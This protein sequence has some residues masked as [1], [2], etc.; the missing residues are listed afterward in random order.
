M[1]KLTRRSPLNAKRKNIVCAS[2][3]SF[4][5]AIGTNGLKTH[6][7]ISLFKPHKPA[8]K[9][10]IFW[11]ERSSLMNVALPGGRQTL[12]KNLIRFGHLKATQS[13][14]SQRPTEMLL[15]TQTLTY[16]SSKYLQAEVSQYG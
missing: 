9:L 7:P 10:K 6:R 15:R 14:L 1:M 5:F 16:R 13:F 4:L 3:R 12:A 8:R 2:M 11:R